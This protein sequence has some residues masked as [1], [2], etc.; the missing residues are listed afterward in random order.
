MTKE[1]F[2]RVKDFTLHLPQ[3]RTQVSDGQLLDRCQMAL[4][5][6][7]AAYES[8]A[9]EN[10]SRFPAHAEWAKPGEVELL[11][12]D[13]PIPPHLHRQPGPPPEPVHH[14][15]KAAPSRSHHKKR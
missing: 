12:P 1:E 11:T 7:I 5:E 15:K 9:E 14:V 6:L 4:G 13:P 10:E 2:D 3:L 8:E